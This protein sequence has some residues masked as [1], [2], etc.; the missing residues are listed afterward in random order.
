MLWGIGPCTGKGV[1]RLETG[2]VLSTPSSHLVDVWARTSKGAPLIGV[3]AISLPLC[4]SASLNA[5]TF[6]LWSTLHPKEV[7]DGRT[8]PLASLFGGRLIQLTD[9][10]PAP[11]KRQ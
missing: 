9:G 8:V 11:S 6:D 3:S 4:L 2:S 1:P 10:Q 7:G 5:V